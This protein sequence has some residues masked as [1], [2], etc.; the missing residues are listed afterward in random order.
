MTAR[1]KI[2]FTMLSVILSHML[3]FLEFVL[4]DELKKLGLINHTKSQE[5]AEP[6]PANKSGCKYWGE[7]DNSAQQS[8]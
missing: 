8:G 6:F 3:I 1:W 5:G 2:P 4:T 7:R